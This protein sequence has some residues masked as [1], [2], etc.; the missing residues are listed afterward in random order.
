MDLGTIRSRLDRR[1]YSNPQ[2]FC[3]VSACPHAPLSDPY[4]R[5]QS[6]QKLSF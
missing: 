4:S 3:D 1:E 5:R 6:A 2:E